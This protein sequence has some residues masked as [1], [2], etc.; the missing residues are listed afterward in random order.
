MPA[1]RL[2]MEQGLVIGSVY[3]QNRLIV[4]GGKPPEAAACSRSPL[5]WDLAVTSRPWTMSS[6]MA[7]SQDACPAVSKAG[8]RKPN[9]RV[10]TR[11]AVADTQSEPPLGLP[12]PAMCHNR[13]VALPSA[14]SSAPPC[15]LSRSRA[16]AVARQRQQA[17]A[18]WHG[19]A[20]RRALCGTQLATVATSAYTPRPSARQAQAGRKNR[21]LSI[22]LCRIFVHPRTLNEPLSPSVVSLLCRSQ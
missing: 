4:I 18:D 9:R 21:R 16:L 17:G 3:L 2:A 20:I 1:T 19:R 22:S 15:A 12:R 6:R 11:C 7:R 8:T 13:D 14:C 10:W 5:A